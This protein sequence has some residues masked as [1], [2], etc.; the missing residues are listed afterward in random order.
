MNFDDYVAARGAALL[1]FAYV[2]TQDSHAAEDIVQ[3]ALA[4][5]FRHWRRISR[6]EHPDSYVR[7]MITNT[8]LGSKRRRW[9]KEQPSGLSPGEGDS[10]VDH[11]ESVVGQDEARTVLAVLAPRARAIL[12]L[13]YYDDLDD[14]EIS[15]ILNISQ[16]T[17]RATASRALAALRARQTTDKPLY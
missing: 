17:V 5:A 6:T 14:L 16:S 1:R 10:F 3:S 7:R 9:S 2:L 15:K 12:V 4:E 11:A 13:R 8:Y